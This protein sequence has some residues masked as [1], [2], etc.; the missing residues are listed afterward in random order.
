MI[1]RMPTFC[2]YFVDHNHQFGFT[3][4][5]LKLEINLIWCRWALIIKLLLNVL[6]TNYAL[7]YTYCGDLVCLSYS[8]VNHFY[9]SIFN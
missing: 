8:H 4:F 5:P 2:L 6:L 9:K 1:S 3:T 7:K